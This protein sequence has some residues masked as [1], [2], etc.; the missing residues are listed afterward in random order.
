MDKEKKE[1][2]APS[3]TIVKD[4]V[5]GMTFEPSQAAA[6]TEFQGRTYYFCSTGCL[7]KFRRNPAAGPAPGAPAPSE[8]AGYAKLYTCPMDP[9]VVREAPGSCP[10]CGM[11]LELQ[12]TSLE[13]EDNAELDAMHHRLRIS[14]FLTLPILVIAMGGMVPAMRFKGSVWIQFVLAAP[15]VLWAGLPF[16]RRAWVSVL[17]RS[18]NMFTLI[19]VGTG[20]AYI[21]SVVAV[22]L[23]G[24]LP[25]SF[26]GPDG[27]PEVYFEASAVIITLALLGQVIEIRA[28]RKTNGAVR[29]LMKLAPARARIV[30]G[31]GAEMDIPLDQVK[32]GDRLRVRPGDAVPVD[33]TV[34]EGH[35]SVDESMLTGEP[36]PVE[37][38]RGSRATGGTVN[39]NGTF[40]MQA[41]KVGRDTL[42]ARIVQM[43]SEAQRTRAPIQ[44]VADRVS[45]FFV[46]AVILASL[47]AFGVWSY[48][49]PEP[50]MVYAL[51]NAVAVLIIA[52][53]CA[54]GLATPMSVMVGTGRAARAGVLLKNA[55]ALELLGKVDTLVVDKTGTLTE[56]K[57]CLTSIITTGI[58]TESELVSMAA[59]LE[60]GSEH[61]LAAAILSA[62]ELRGLPLDRTTGF[63]SVTGRGVRGTVNGKKVVVGNRAMIDDLGV[64]T[65]SFT[66]AAENMRQ[67]GHTVVFV[68]VDGVLA[69]LLGVSDPIKRSSEEAIRGLHREGIRLVM[70]TGDSRTTAAIVARSLGIDHVEAEVTPD[71]KGEVI[72]RLQ[73][74]GRIVAMAGDGINDAPALAMA[75]VGIAMGTGT[76]VAIRSAG[77]TLVKGDLRAVARARKLS[78]ATMR[79]IRQNLFFAFVYNSLGVPIAAGALYPAVGLLLNPM[80]ASAA[81]T[82]SSISVIGNALRLR[83]IKL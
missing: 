26:L 27:S 35:S 58:W 38:S 5:C 63:A 16:F 71:R 59:S 46:P 44:R 69:G 51:V 4:P 14:L 13:E 74:E 31:G 75:H 81:M 2:P 47:V 83:N 72:R 32:P 33:G 43:V 49:G 39:G 82:F 54:L 40:I 37:K 6:Q 22:L 42:L 56:G 79:N 21:Y 20:T 50:R 7:E 10:V 55:E 61:P 64:D 60:R 62:A 70:L 19:G 73:A 18:L 80:I 15:V 66:L 1:A 34:L 8:T 76:D 77:I 17:N 25:D 53:P 9:E 67:K 41:E 23:P 24:L 11:A 68:L 12:T 45:S 3:S 52:C 30:D 65:G 57:P 48:A 36:V 28:R 29:A 78:K